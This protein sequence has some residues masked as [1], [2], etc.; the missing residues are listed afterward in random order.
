LAAS[1]A[2]HGCPAIA[3]DCLLLELDQGRL[4]GRPSYAGLRLWDD[5][6]AT[7]FERRPALSDV[8]HYTSKKR[9]LADDGPIPFWSDSAPVRR[10]Y[11]LAA[12]EEMAAATAAEIAPLAPRQAFIELFSHAYK[13]DIA[14]RAML[15]REFE[16]LRRVAALPLFYRLAFPHDF[17]ALPEVREAIVGHLSGSC[18][19]ALSTMD[20]GR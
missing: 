15:A 14:D 10:M 13:L 8:A 18:H 4:I 20:D 16:T 1:F 19:P 7:L 12:E 17:A 9:L 5:S 6:V 3:D 11:F 2:H